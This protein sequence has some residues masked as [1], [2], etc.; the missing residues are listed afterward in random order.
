METAALNP[1]PRTAER[2]AVSAL[3]QR[4]QKTVQGAFAAN[5]I[6][7]IRLR[8]NRPVQLITSRGELMLDSVGTLSEQEARQ[9]LE[10]ICRHSVYAWENELCSG[11]LTLPGGVRVG[12]CGKPL[13]DDGRIIR[14]TCV[15]G[16]NIRIAREVTGCSDGVI[17]YLYD[18]G[19]IVSTLIAA[20]PNGG[21]TTLLRDIARSLSRT[22]CG[23]RPVKVAIA[24]ERNEIAGCINGVPSLDVGLRTDVMDGVPKRLSI[25]MLIRSM[26]PDVIITDEIGG[27][28]DM[29]AVAEAAKCGV[30]VI[31]SI[32]AGSSK[33]LSRK[34]WLVDALDEGVFGRVLL[35][36]RQGSRLTVAP[37]DMGRYV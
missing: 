30:A 14:F 2:E 4:M 17:K 19:N 13:V 11:Y 22:G 26:S 25:F 31:A 29:R 32:H 3:P 37:I 7:E 18:G 33:E 12:I 28:E 20:P 35:L 5:S 8:V 21:K 23:V 27:I 6:E 36:H 34:R 16:F 24:D 15:T 1:C 9:M 10:N